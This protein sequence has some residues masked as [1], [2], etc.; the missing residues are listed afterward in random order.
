[1]HHPLRAQALGLSCVALLVRWCARRLKPFVQSWRNAFYVVA[2]LV[3][4][5]SF[6]CCRLTPDVRSVTCFLSVVCSP[7]LVCDVCQAVHVLAYLGALQT[8]TDT[9][10]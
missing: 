5:R 8:V 9:G 1:M 3:Q 7:L 2:G 6:A 10:S 4:V